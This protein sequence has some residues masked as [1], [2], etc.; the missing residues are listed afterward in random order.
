M[1]NSTEMLRKDHYFSTGGV[2][3]L[4]SQHTIFLSDSEASNNLF[5][6]FIHANNFFNKKIM[7]FCTK[8]SFHALI[9]DHALVF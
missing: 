8:N 2:P 4:I 5:S 9:K 6:F 7:N 1:K 3:I